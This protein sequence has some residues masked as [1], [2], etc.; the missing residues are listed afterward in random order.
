MVTDI[1]FHPQQTIVS[2]GSEGGWN[3][4]VFFSPRASERRVLLKVEVCHIFS[5]SHF[6][7]FTSFHLFIFAPSHLH[8]FSSS[9]FLIF[10]SS[11]LLIFTS[12]HLLIFTSSHLPIFSSSHLHTF[13]SSHLL[14]F[15]PSHLHIFSSSH[16][17]S[18]LSVLPSCPL[19]LLF[20]CSLALLLPSC[21]LALLPSSLSFFSISL[22]RRE[23]CQ[24]GVPKRNPFARNEAK[25]WG[26]IANLTDPAQPFARNEVR[27]SKTEVT[28]RFSNFGC[29]MKFD[30]QKLRW[31]CDFQT[32]S[33]TFSHEMKSDRQ[34]LR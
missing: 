12:S 16:R 10:T 28:L 34:K 24:R 29:K 14:I 25:N 1:R 11:H 33:A 22:L 31:D 20:S 32:S 30:P 2:S 23:Q 19:A 26:K 5:S 9:H 7:I 8:I 21:P 4:H 3:Y 13:S 27:W 17:L 18:L 15:T 6:L